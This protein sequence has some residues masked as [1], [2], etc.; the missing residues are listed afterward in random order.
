MNFKSLKIF[1]MMSCSHDFAFPRSAPD[2]SYSQ[3]CRLCGA[4]Y[5]YDWQEMRRK[6][7]IVDRVVKQE[8]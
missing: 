2:G 6:K 1:S 7:R 4:E 3:V 8:I 5:E